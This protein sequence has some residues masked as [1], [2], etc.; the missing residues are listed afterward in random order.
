ML[1]TLK[2]VKK[3]MGGNILFEKLNLELKPGEKLGLGGR[4]GSG[5]STIYK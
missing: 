2:D 1:I 4:N 3:I 5:K